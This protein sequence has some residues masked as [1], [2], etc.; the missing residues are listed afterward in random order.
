[1]KTEFECI[2]FCIL[3]ECI[4]LCSSNVFNKTDRNE[5]RKIKF[6]FQCC[7]SETLYAKICVGTK[8]MKCDWNPGQDALFSVVSDAYFS[9]T[10]ECLWKEL[11]QN[12]KSTWIFH[13]RSSYRRWQKSNILFSETFCNTSANFS[14]WRSAS[15]F[16]PGSHSKAPLWNNCMARPNLQMKPPVVSLFLMKQHGPGQCDMLFVWIRFP[17]T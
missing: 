11:H 16:L 15:V 3:F 12:D 9:S 5:T 7:T 1:M 6:P 14:F 17:T 4:F 2:L 13:Q 8:C 10:E